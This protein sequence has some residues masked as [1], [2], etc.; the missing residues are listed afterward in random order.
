MK[1]TISY[2]HL[3]EYQNIL[4]NLSEVYKGFFIENGF[5]YTKEIP[6]FLTNYVRLP[7]WE[8]LRNQ[9]LWLKIKAAGE[10]IQKDPYWY[11]SCQP[12]YLP[13]L[14]NEI[15][16]LPLVDTKEYESMIALYRKDIEKILSSISNVASDFGMYLTHYGT[17]GSY[18][19]NNYTLTMSIIDYKASFLQSAIFGIGAYA[20]HQSMYAFNNEMLWRERQR[21]IDTLIK[22]TQL[23]KWYSLE[24]SIL[25]SS[26]KHIPLNYR[27]ETNKFLDYYGLFSPKSSNIRV[28]D[29]RLLISNQ[30]IRLTKQELLIVNHML[31]R[32]AG[33]I[34]SYDTIAEIVW[35]DKSYA[36]FSL[37]TI[38]KTI[39]RI[40][41]KVKESGIHQIFIKNSHK[42]GYYI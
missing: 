21:A 11:R 5:F 3:I 19:I 14:W 24:Y 36:K 35:G 6:E 2:S 29:D 41:K 38:S 18:S 13:E 1:V 16:K 39:E 32:E 40:N 15:E 34:V 25:E 28:K 9:R 30:N 22:S 31:E 23:G 8:C 10:Q 12:E 17:T 42:M 20:V 33:S 4:Y 7:Y 27:K 37:Q 26:R